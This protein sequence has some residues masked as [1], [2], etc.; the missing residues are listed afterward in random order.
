MRELERDGR[1]WRT[2]HAVALPH[3]DYALTPVGKSLKTLVQDLDRWG[4]GRRLM[5]LSGA[6]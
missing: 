1:V 3:T 5:G 4:P 2:V 6:G